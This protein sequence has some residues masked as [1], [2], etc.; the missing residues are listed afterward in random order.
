MTRANFSI[1]H[2][3]RA[4]TRAIDFGRAARARVGPHSFRRVACCGRTDFVLLVRRPSPPSSAA[5]T[6]HLRLQEAGGR[7]PAAARHPRDAPAPLPAVRRRPSLVRFAPIPF[8]FFLS[9]F[10][11]FLVRF[12][13]FS[14]YSPL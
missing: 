3:T 11:V 13:V 14:R 4:V 9:C 1:S 7:P 10:V 8:S 2:A 6:R 12:L 5:R